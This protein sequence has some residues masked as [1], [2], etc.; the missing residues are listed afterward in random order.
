MTPLYFRLIIS[1]FQIL[2]N[3]VDAL[4]CFF[5]G[6]NKKPDETLTLLAL[7]KGSLFVDSW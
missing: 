7:Y 6:I 1:N 3:E 5:D 2:K 4:A